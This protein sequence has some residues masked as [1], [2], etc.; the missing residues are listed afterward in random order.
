MIE[1]YK[2]MR[3]FD[4]GEWMK[5]FPCQ[6]QIQLEDMGQEEEIQRGQ[7]GDLLYPDSG[8]YLECAW[9]GQVVKAAQL[10]AFKKYIHQFNTWITQT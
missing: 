6:R 3:D 4:I 2:V 1:W 7:Q 5:P 9:S 8:K 10:T